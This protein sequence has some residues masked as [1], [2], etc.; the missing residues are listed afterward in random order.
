MKRS[1]QLILIL[2]ALGAWHAPVSA[3]IMDLDWDGEQYEEP[4]GSSF[5]VIL[6][7]SDNVYGAHF[8][9]GL[10]LKNTPVFGDYFVALFSN[11]KEDA[12]Y[13]GMG[14]TLRLMP[15]WRVAPFVG[16]GGSYNWSSKD[17][18][19]AQQPADQPPDRGASYAAGHVETG[20]RFW[21]TNRARLL[22]IMGRY[23]WT[24]LDGDR[25]YWLVGLGTGTNW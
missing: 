5:A 9:R 17:Q 20:V 13:G 22:E 4:A 21:M 6:N 18:S 3:D 8:G 24:A 23:T 7:P 10:W 25:D 15:H 14:L 11:G 16:A 12:F 1:C 2:A 19:A